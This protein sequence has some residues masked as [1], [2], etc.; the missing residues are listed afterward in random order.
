MDEYTIIGNEDKVSWVD[1]LVKES[2]RKSVEGLG[3]DL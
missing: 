2:F 1:V 3:Q